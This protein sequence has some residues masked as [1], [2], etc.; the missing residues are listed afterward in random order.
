VAAVSVSCARMNEQKPD[1]V[2]SVFFEEET[3]DRWAQ[4]AE[5]GAVSRLETRTGA[6]AARCCPRAAAG[7]ER[8]GHNRLGRGRGTWAKARG[9]HGAGPQVG[10]ARGCWGATA[11]WAG[12]G[13]QAAVGGERWGGGAGP[14]SRARERAALG[15]GAGAGRE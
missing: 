8:A 4:H 15:W 13:G 7:A 2:E 11:A 14:Q 3:Y 10:C 9:V 12:Q 5:Q 6:A 1:Q